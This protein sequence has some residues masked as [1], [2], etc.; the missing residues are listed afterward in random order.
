MPDRLTRRQALKVA[1][2][3]ACSLAFRPPPPLLA[4]GPVGLGRV[5]REWINL[6]SEPNFRARRLNIIPR[7]TLISLLA[8]ET[9]ESGPVYNPLWFHVPDGYVHSG[10]LQLVRWNP[11]TPLENVPG[12]GA[13]FE[14]SVPYTRSFRAADPASAPIYRLY[15]QSTH[16]VEASVVGSDGRRWYRVVDDRLHVR[17]HVRAEHLRLI[18]HEE[19]T[20]ISP[21]VPVGA[22]R[23]EL[24]LA[25]QEVI[26][27]E[28]EREVLRA[29][30]STGVPSSG[31]TPNGIPTTTPSGRFHIDIKTPLRH[32]G[33]GGVTSDLEAYELPGVPWVAFFHSTGVAFHGTYWHTDFGRP[34]SHGCVNMRTDEARWL[35]RWTH[36][37]AEPGQTLAIG[38]GTLVVV[39]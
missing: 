39:S 14:V 8:E 19:M 18:P 7:D 28:N 6:Y 27:F 36:P 38:R 21:E 24:S 4:D 13:L 31:P 1:G 5:A 15:Y 2:L 17:Y 9:P 22:K 11:Q 26:A 34:R 33:D 37:L 30:V 12:E 29:R 35:Y 10:N 32:M 25:R 3:A 16:W 23:I 20:P